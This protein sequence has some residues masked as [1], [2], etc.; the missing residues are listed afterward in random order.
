MKKN[1]LIVILCFCISL[2]VFAQEQKTNAPVIPYPKECKVL[3][4]NFILSPETKIV[5]PSSLL[6]NDIDYL[7]SY[8]EKEYGFTLEKAEK[9]PSNNNYILFQF[10]DWEAGLKENYHLTINEKYISIIAEGNGAGNL[11]AI[12]TLIQLFS[13]DKTKSIKLPCVEIKDSPRFEWR[14]M[15]LDVCR[16]FF[17]VSFIKKYIDLLAMYKMNTF[18]WHLTDD[19]GWRIEIK[20]Y[21]KLTEIGAWRKGTMIGPYKDQKF[22]SM[23]YGGFYTQEQIK[24]VVTYAEKKH[25]TIV[26]EIEMPGH[27]VAA[28]SSYPWLSCTGKQIDVEKAWGVFEDVYCTKDS[29]FNFLQDVLDE[30]TILFPG[31]YIHIGGDES[32]KTRWKVCANCQA[33]IKS[34][35]LKD[36]H[37]LQSYFIKRIEKYLNSK[38]KQIIGWNEIL[39]GGLAPNAAVMSWQGTEGGV[40]AAKQKHYAVMTPGSHCYFDHYQASPADEPLAFGGYTPLEKVYSYEPIPSELNEDEQHYIL[41]AQANIWTE[42]ILDEKQVEY[43][44]MP[45]MMAL[46][47]VVWSPKEN[48]NETDFLNRLQTQ[49]LLLDKL[50]INYAK[51]LYKV[52]QHVT[53]RKSDFDFSTD[54]HL[55]VELKANPILGK[56]YFTE[57]GND[58][59][60]V[61]GTA[62]FDLIP[63][64]ENTT[65]SAGLLDIK[66]RK[67]LGKSTMASYHFSK[68]TNK[69]VSLTT[70]PNEAYKGEG[71]FT[72]VNS[73]IGDKP[74]VNEQW[75]GWKGED[76]EAIVDLENTEN[77]HS[78]RCGFLKEE[79]SWIYLPKQVEFSI[80][81]DG[82]I[83]KT[84]G[85]TDY[86]F[87]E[88]FASI[89]FKII[90]ARYIKIIAKNYGKI[91]SGKS[92][93]GSKS[94][95][96]CDEIFID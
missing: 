12:Q 96:F 91:P 5:A 24:E 2:S 9:I 69:N 20:K 83:F 48:R 41:G 62:Y 45:R 94:W 21:P 49:F 68:A 61:G 78:I 70:Q 23:P 58:V 51:A 37:E 17:P 53:S 59:K 8:L 43:M 84:L 60:T 57:S 47:E 25:I 52:E 33:R 74:R 82:K 67:W 44:L 63:I 15:H 92:G 81:I 35:H 89:D 31:K 93:A 64:R 22:D 11:Y 54:K 65:I 1:S 55:S 56:I 50:G 14:G 36:E 46:S 79:L 72:L 88:H 71:G 90:K 19:Q 27:S 7:N 6:N 38:G 26:P 80:S 32:P 86:Y 73:V 39:E 85:K 40:A 16:H 76:M 13:L 4:G 10:P 66:E 30:V 42:Y 95:L 77:I 87:D 75:L 28:I 29:V 34:E 18:H 3:P